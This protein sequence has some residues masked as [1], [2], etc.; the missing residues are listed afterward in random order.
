[1]SDK[2][3]TFRYDDHHVR[4]FVYATM[5]WALVGMGMGVVIAALLFI[6]ELNLAPYLTFG[7]LRPVHTNAVIFA[8]CG[9]I[10][11]GGVYY[12]SQRLLKTRMISDVLTAIH[13]WG[14]QAIIVSAAI[15]LP[16]GITQSREYAEL[17]WPVALLVAVV[18]AA[19][20]V[21]AGDVR[22]ADPPEVALTIEQHRFVPEEIRV[23]AGTPFVLVITNFAPVDITPLITTPG[24]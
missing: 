5:F 9:N 13:F 6:P 7:R 17:E 21:V 24:P 1:M 11:F 10:I 15:T 2:L 18:V 14:W 23:R 4:L 20:L 22:A 16:L 12:S 19:L 3:E 8:F